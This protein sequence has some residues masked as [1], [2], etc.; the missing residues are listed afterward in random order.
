M[1]QTEVMSTDMTK[2]CTKATC[3]A[4]ATLKEVKT[5]QA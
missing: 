3:D 1:D 2:V 5:V 4:L